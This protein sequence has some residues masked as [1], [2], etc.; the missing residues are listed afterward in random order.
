M[1]AKACS[2]WVAAWSPVLALSSR[3]MKSGFKLMMCS[4]KYYLAPVLSGSSSDPFRLR[5]MVNRGNFLYLLGD[6]AFLLDMA[7]SIS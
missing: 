1:L 7:K 5:N 6:Q 4:F 2:I 3:F